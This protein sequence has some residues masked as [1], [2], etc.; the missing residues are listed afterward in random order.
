MH[1]D[2]RSK[3]IPVGPTRIPFRDL[4]PQI[5]VDQDRYQE[6]CECSVTFGKYQG[7]FVCLKLPFASSHDDRGRDFIQDPRDYVRR[8]VQLLTSLAAL[9]FRV[10]KV[11]AFSDALEEPRPYLLVEDISDGGQATFIDSKRNF[12]RTAVVNG[13]EVEGIAYIRSL[14][15]WHEVQLELISQSLRAHAYGF[16]FGFSPFCCVTVKDRVGTVWIHDVGEGKQVERAELQ[17]LRQTEREFLE[18]G[19]KIGA[20][21]AATNFFAALTI[22]NLFVHTSPKIDEYMI[23]P[24]YQQLAQAAPEL[25]VRSFLMHQCL[26]RWFGDELAARQPTITPLYEKC[27]GTVFGAAALNSQRIDLTA[28]VKIRRMIT[29][30]MKPQESMELE[31]QLPWP[32][33]CDICRSTSDSKF[34]EPAWIV[35]IAD[36]P[37][38]V[39]AANGPGFEFMSGPFR[40]VQAREFYER[41]NGQDRSL[42]MRAEHG[43]E[44]IQLIEDKSI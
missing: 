38:L 17:A 9:G 43:S 41:I 37:Q 44:L 23:E 8:S 42:W 31:L 19:M 16:H 22:D 5:A 30:F 33:A 27:L 15:N 36:A 40:E 10:P 12:R 18:F 14:V 2:L 4:V 28:L 25:T 21:S 1:A 20:P 26:S 32:V 13:T 7:T 24:I 29:K 6:G 34:I 35:R 11:L 39:R 3:Q